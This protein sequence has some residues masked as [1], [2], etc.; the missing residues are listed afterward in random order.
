MIPVRD[1]KLALGSWQG[2]YLCEHRDRGK[3]RNL[4]ITVWGEQGDVPQV[5]VGK[6]DSQ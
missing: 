1:G 5:G 2:F 4:I 3:A 6:V